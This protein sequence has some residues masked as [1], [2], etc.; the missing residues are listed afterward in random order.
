M[1]NLEFNDPMVL[2]FERV[3]A[4]PEEAKPD[5]REVDRAYVEAKNKTDSAATPQPEPQAQ[6]QRPPAPIQ[7]ER[8]LKAGDLVMV[9]DRESQDWRFAVYEALV[10]EAIFPHVAKL[11]DPPCRLGWK[12]VRLPTQEERMAHYEETEG[13][14]AASREGD[15]W[16]TGKPTEPGVYLTTYDGCDYSANKEKGKGESFCRWDGS[17]WYLDSGY[18]DAAI[19]HDT[20]SYIQ[21]RRYKVL[22]K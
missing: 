14:T 2:K 22:A 15:G 3:P 18:R 21:E 12:Y 4:K 7:A 19:G 17:N 6:V 8:E 13:I 1:L 9:R 16:L 20:P 5:Q 10:P 11:L